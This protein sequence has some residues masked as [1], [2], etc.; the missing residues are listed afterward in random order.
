MSCRQAR[1]S[2]GYRGDWSEGIHRCITSKILLVDARRRKEK[3]SSKAM[4]SGRKQCLKDVQVG[5]KEEWS[6]DGD[7]LNLLRRRFGAGGF[8]ESTRKSTKKNK[9]HRAL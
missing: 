4:A 3:R 7:A 2:C 8:E 1:H 9:R 5:R 6:G